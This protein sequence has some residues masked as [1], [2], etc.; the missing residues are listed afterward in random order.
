MTDPKELEILEHLEESLIEKEEYETVGVVSER[1]A[2]IK[3]EKLVMATYRFPNGNV[4]T[5]GY[6]DQQI[7]ELQGRF[8]SELKEKIKER[9]D[10]RTQWNG[11]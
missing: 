8:T 1:I 2:E 10:H 9:S 11:F 4:A 7:V 5:F 6:D 3:K